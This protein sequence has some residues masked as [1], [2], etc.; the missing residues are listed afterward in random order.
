MFDMTLQKYGKLAPLKIAKRDLRGNL[1]WTC[2]CDC[3]RLATVRAD[4]L[5]MGTTKSCGCIHDKG[6]N[7]KHNLSKTRLYKTW[8]NIKQR[9]F[10]VKNTSYQNY[11]TRG[12]VMCNE[13]FNDFK[14]FYDWCMSNGYSDSLTIDRIDN[15]GNYEPL[16]C[17]FITLKQQ[18]L[19][20][21]DNHILEYDGISQTITQWAE[22][23]N[24][25]KYTLSSRINALGWDVVSALEKPARSKYHNGRR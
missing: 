22:T 19:N 16:N 25:S 4:R 20:K 23:L 17:Q 15:N 14:K 2:Q 1:Y 5:K 13:W 6:N 24:I 9:C 10:N 8:V 11:G 21:S 12:I 3:G 7:T 18:Q